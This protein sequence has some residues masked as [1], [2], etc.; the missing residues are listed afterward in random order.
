E[1]RGALKWTRSSEF[2]ESAYEHVQLHGFN[3]IAKPI[4]GVFEGDPV[5]A[6]QEAWWKAQA[7]VVS[8]IP[9]G[10]RDV[11]IVPMGYKVGWQGGATGTGAALENIVIVV[12]RATGEIVTS[13]PK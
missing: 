5:I 6:T 10:V 12:D 4:H 3:D 13:Y 9:Q 2:G 8:P 7:S 11:F 1:L